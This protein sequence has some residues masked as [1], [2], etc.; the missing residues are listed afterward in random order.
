[1]D[2][3]VRFWDPT[4]GGTRVLSIGPGPF[5]NL[6]RQ[7]AFS[8]E[9]RYLATAN[10]NGTISILRVPVP[11]AAYSPGSP[12]KLPDPVALATR[13]SP[14]DALDRKNIPAGWLIQAGGGNPE[15]APAELVAVLGDSDFHAP[16]MV[17]SQDGNVLALPGPDAIVLCDARTGKYLRTLTGLAG[18]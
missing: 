9:G 10:D 15:K 4:S 5:G 18:R 13:P 7:V 2:R 14:A 1:A 16:G 8:P 6:V 12:K 17:H 11:P 3:T